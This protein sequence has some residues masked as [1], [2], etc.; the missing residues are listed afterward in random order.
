[1][2]DEGEA[3]S[4]CGRVEGVMYVVLDSLEDVWG[5]TG[6]VVSQCGGYHLFLQS[7]LAN[8]L[9]MSPARE[10]LPLVDLFFGDLVLVQETR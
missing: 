7:Y 5:T 10:D 2:G 1:M 9:P 8:S 6:P 3:H 4:S